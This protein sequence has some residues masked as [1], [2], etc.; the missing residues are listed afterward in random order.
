MAPVTDLADLLVRAVP[1][2]LGGGSVQLI[3]FFLKRRVEMHTADVAAGKTTSET[4]A[5][6]V[7]SAERSLL[8][9]DQVRDR[10]VRRAEVLMTDLQHA[11][12]EM[13]RMQIEIRE[14]RLEVAA[15][16]RELSQLRAQTD[17]LSEGEAS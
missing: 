11:E 3:L 9:S 13:T 5:V 7:A 4:D 1:V 8:L 15:L 10:A 14:Y 6:V 2:M 12:G 17:V 16:R